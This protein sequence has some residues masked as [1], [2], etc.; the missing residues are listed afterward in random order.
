MVSLIFNH[1]GVGLQKTERSVL[2]HVG[3]GSSLPL[4]RQVMVFA[5]F[6]FRQCS[7]ERSTCFKKRWNLLDPESILRRGWPAR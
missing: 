5:R 3:G 2:L 7:S 6:R 1:P 4:V